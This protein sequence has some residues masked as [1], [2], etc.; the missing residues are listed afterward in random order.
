[1]LEAWQ[2]RYHS[3]DKIQWITPR[4]SEIGLLIPNKQKWT[5]SMHQFQCCLWQAFHKIIELWIQFNFL[6][7][8]WIGWIP[9]I[10]GFWNP[11]NE[12]W[13]WKAQILELKKS[14]PMLPNSNQFPGNWTS[15]INFLAFALAFEWI[16]FLIFFMKYKRPN[17]KNLFETLVNDN[18]TTLKMVPT[19]IPFC[20]ARVSN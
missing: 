14:F 5:L 15:K 19:I 18:I 12:T 7:W 8:L 11:E 10:L 17:L 1:M 13:I 16:I 9:G 3:M 2:E 6:R 20:L 4:S